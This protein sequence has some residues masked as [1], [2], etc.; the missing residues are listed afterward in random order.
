SRHPT[1]GER[2]EYTATKFPR[3]KVAPMKSNARLILGGLLLAGVITTLPDAGAQTPPDPERIFTRAETN[4]DGKI[5]R[6][7]WKKFSE[8]APKLKADPLGADS[9]FDR[10][11]TNKDGFLTLDEFMKIAE[12]RA[13]KGPEPKKE[14]VAEV[15][16]EKAATP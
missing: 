3:R 11:D 9:L 10:L 15:A 16:I 5:S 6:E 12:M 8:A 7:E 13:K 4:G 14:P 1:Q 2:L